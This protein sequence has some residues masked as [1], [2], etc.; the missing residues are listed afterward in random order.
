VSRAHVTALALVNWKGVFYERYRLDR[1]V[2]ALEGANGAGKTTVMI[3]AYMVLLPDM[4]RLRF[5]NLGESGASGGDRGIWGRL[6]EPGRPS[7]AALDIQQP[8]GQRVVIG[9]RL[10]RLAE[11][12]VEPTAFLIESMAADTLLSQLFLLQ[13]DDHDQVCELDEV[14]ESARRVGARLEVFRS[15]KDYFAALFERGITPLRLASDEERNK[16]NEMLR[17]S[18]TGGIS[19]VLTSELRSFLLKEESGLGDVLGRMR[20]NL[21]A[22]HRT[23]GEVSEARS[24]ERD[25]S[26]V[27]EAGQAMFSAALHAARAAADEVA[28]RVELARTALTTAQRAATELNSEVAEL[29]AREAALDERFRAARA[30][31]ETRAAELERL[32][33]A[34]ALADQ[35]RGLDL[36]LTELERQAE[37]AASSQA[38]AVA[39]RSLCRLARDQMQE[40]YQRAA[41]GLAH[42]QHGLDELHRRAHAHRQLGR[43][44]EQARLLL[45]LPELTLDRVSEELVRLQQNRQSMLVARA[46]S[47]RD[48]DSAT[49]RRDEQRRALAALAMLEAASHHPAAVSGVNA[50]P[51][52]SD[53]VASLQR[54]RR[55]LARLAEREAELAQLP[56]LE[57][58]QSELAEL[59]TRQAAVQARATQLNLACGPGA[60]HELESR[61]DSREQALRLAQETL[62]HAEAQLESATHASLQARERQA[63]LE[64]RALS[65]QTLAAA[66]E[67]AGQALGETLSSAADL[68]RAR[69]SLADNMLALAAQRERTQSQRE[70]WLR[71]AADLNGPGAALDPELIRLRDELGAELVLGRFDHVRDAEAATLEARLGPLIHALVVPD[72]AAAAAA[73]VDKPRTLESVWLVRSGVDLDSGVASSAEQDVIVEERLG[74]RITRRPARPTLGAGA[75]AARASE[76]QKCAEDAAGELEALALRARQLAG[77]RRDLELLA[78]RQD[79]W[80]AGDPASE[81][82]ALALSQAPLAEAE[83]SARV[84]LQAARERRSALRSELDELHSLLPD[85]SLLEPSDHQQL[86]AAVTTRIAAARRAQ[87]ELLQVGPARDELSELIEVLRQ[88]SV[89]SEDS[90]LASSQIAALDADLERDYRAA[91]ALEE[92]LAH[93][94][95]EHWHDAAEALGSQT[96]LVPVLDAQHDQA[97]AA[98]AAADRAVI[99]GDARWEQATRSAQDAQAQ[100]GASAAARARLASELETLGGAPEAARIEHVARALSAASQQL[101][102][103]ERGARAL[104]GD[105]AR[106]RERA[107][108][109]TRRASKAMAA[110][111]DEEQQARPLQSAWQELKA[112]AE[113]AELMADQSGAG[114]TSLELAAA[115]T[116]RR[117]LLIDRLDRSRGGDDLARQIRELT[118]PAALLEAWQ[119][120]RDWLRRRVPAQITQAGDPLRALERLRDHLDMLEGRL[121]RQESDLRGA[122]ADVGRGIDVQ[123]RRARGQVR[124]LNAQL[125]GVRFGSIAAIRVEMRR[126]ERMEQI[127]RALREGEAQ[128]LLFLPS[129]PIDEALEEIFR[130]YGGGRG[131]GQRLLD[132]R[133]YVELVVEIKRQANEHWEAASP[134]RL[135]TGEAIG[136][137]AA[138][139]MVVLTEWERDSNL[140]RARDNPGSLRFLFL[141]EAN[142]LSRDNLAVL[143]ELCKNLD[144]QLMI[145]APEVARAEGN[146]TYR[147]VRHLSDDGREEVIV[148]GRR[149]VAERVPEA[150]AAQGGT[151]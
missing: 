51:N 66:A 9:V 20:A 13:R 116:S 6:G 140:L 141:D 3:A 28:G 41:L 98:L 146:T 14:R 42:L 88:P 114:S 67:R 25:I 78:S 120:A 40:A 131:G 24:V 37:C 151:E 110:M 62:S 2:T 71:L 147:L 4:S 81:L 52:A 5:T 95:A 142:R 76:L 108:Q 58:E 125:E 115:A 69:D 124:R 84:E 119:L 148:S 104:V 65:W 38:Q 137:G 11:P 117:A 82:A 19:R 31:H 87:S 91:A 18:M 101:S 106:M 93:R 121:A 30:Q 59:V 29:A 17:T 135:S 8:D 32:R 94:H 113:S 35:L 34:S 39:E 49:C 97:R 129:L 48:R 16:L 132:Y 50:Q 56:I 10:R 77:A 12:S 109:A 96:A 83:R 7:Y 144:L 21:E 15:I 134:T 133:E 126:I 123:V 145:A 57:R 143:F 27:Y 23:R 36:E 118:G 150:T 127:L 68:L 112:R 86:L 70:T 75:R 111:H 55:A 45:E 60:A 99:E 80:S 103:L 128:E 47:E 26:S 63:A 72:P 1:H 122:S 54:A 33:R 139:M 89:Q 74:V 22:C 46:R 61:S 73:L 44:L 92:V 90:A 79:V 107:E 85:R 130:R 53:E 102:E 43:G 105:L 100:R 149:A 64:A 136:V 138:L